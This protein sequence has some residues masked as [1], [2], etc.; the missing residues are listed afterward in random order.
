MTFHHNPLFR[1]PAI[2]TEARVVSI[3]CCMLLF[4]CCLACLL[5]HLC[6]TKEGYEDYTIKRMFLWK[7]LKSS[8]ALFK[9]GSVFYQHHQAP[10]VSSDEVQITEDLSLST[11]SSFV[12][13][14]ILVLT[15]HKLPIEEA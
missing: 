3:L 1:M 2:A 13:P 5:P 14:R 15:S 6:D 9:W 11:L 10:S 8:K 12:Y 7:F 4:C